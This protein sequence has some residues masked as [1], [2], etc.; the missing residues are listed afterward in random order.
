MFFYIIMYISTEKGEIK[1]EDIH[2]TNVDSEQKR[3]AIFVLRTQG[4]N[5]S[6]AVKEMTAKLAKEFDNMQK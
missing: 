5:L 4:K 3:K 2:V 6:T 1:M